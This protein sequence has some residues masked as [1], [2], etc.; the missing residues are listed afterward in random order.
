MKTKYV[1]ILFFTLCIVC[2]SQDAHAM[3]GL[4]SQLVAKTSSFFAQDPAQNPHYSFVDRHGEPSLNPI[5]ENNT[6]F[7]CYRNP[8]TGKLSPVFQERLTLNGTNYEFTSGKTKKT[9]SFSAPLDALSPQPVAPIAA[10]IAYATATLPVHATPASKDSCAFKLWY[11]KNPN[12]SY[13]EWKRMGCPKPLMNVATDNPE[14]VTTS[15]GLSYKVYQTG[16][17]MHIFGPDKHPNIPQKTYPGYRANNQFWIS[18]PGQ[19]LIS[20]E[21]FSSHQACIAQQQ[22]PR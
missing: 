21:N 22:M 9:Y 12:V 8:D 16:N 11:A 13:D 1:K 10:P 15:S 4:F 18:L 3:K 19:P 2:I 6:V 5:I 17:Q 14:L 7:V 20:L